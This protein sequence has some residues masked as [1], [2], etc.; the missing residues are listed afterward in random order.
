MATSSM[1]L[2]K[3]LLDSPATGAL[4]AATQETCRWLQRERIDQNVFNPCYELA[5]NRAFPNTS[6]MELQRRVERSD[7]Q[8]LQQAR[9]APS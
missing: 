3:A 7:Q 5:A 9:K 8:I 2:V 4:V 1:N 6:G